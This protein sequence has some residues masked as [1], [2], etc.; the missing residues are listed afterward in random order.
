MHTC[1]SPSTSRLAL[2]LPASSQ[3]ILS[4]CFVLWQGTA[5]PYNTLSALRSHPYAV[6]SAPDDVWIFRSSSHRNLTN[7]P[8]PSSRHLHREAFSDFHGQNACL[9][10]PASSQPGSQDSLYPPR[11]P[12]VTFRFLCIARCCWLPSR[13]P[14]RSLPTR[15]ESPPPLV[16]VIARMTDAHRLSER[17]ARTGTGTHRLPKGTAQEEPRLMRWVEPAGGMFSF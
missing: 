1:P 15:L 4:T 16:P 14:T 9:P 8:R 17:L 3:H 7:C 6:S 2:P 12:A 10:L 13:W 5:A 11:F